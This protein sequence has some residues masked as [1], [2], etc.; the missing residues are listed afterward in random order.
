[1]AGIG[2]PAYWTE[3]TTVIGLVGL[4]LVAIG[5]VY[6]VTASG[7][8]VPPPPGEPQGLVRVETRPTAQAKFSVDGVFTAEWGINWFAYRTGNH[9]L[10]TEYEPSVILDPDTNTYVPV[11]LPADTTFEVLENTTT[12]MIVDLRTGTVTKNFFPLVVA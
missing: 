5:V 6:A 1:M 7:G 10:H 2:D 3:P 9:V 8:Y 11:V 12:E 4:A